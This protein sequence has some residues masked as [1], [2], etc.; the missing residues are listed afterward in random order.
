MSFSSS[1]SSFIV[2]KD[3]CKIKLNPEEYGILSRMRHTNSIYKFIH[4]EEVF[5]EDIKD[6]PGS[7]AFLADAVYGDS[8]NIDDYDMDPEGGEPDEEVPEVIDDTIFGLP[9]VAVG[10]GVGALGLLGLCLILRRS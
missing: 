7:E 2:R 1:S 10:I 4:I 9:K 8:C 6:Y 3:G 5:G